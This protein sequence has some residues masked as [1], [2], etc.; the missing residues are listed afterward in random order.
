MARS[1]KK[2]HYGDIYG[3]CHYVSVEFSEHCSPSVKVYLRD[4]KEHFISPARAFP[5]DEDGYMT[6]QNFMY[7]MFY[8]E[9]LN[10]AARNI[11]E[12]RARA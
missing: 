12:G 1:S 5:C 10:D 4:P 9:G 2:Y 8:A 6:R 7:A 11:R 3:G